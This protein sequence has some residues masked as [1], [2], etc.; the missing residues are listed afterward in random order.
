MT[1]VKF[2][3]LDINECKTQNHTCK[4]QHEKCV[5]LRPGYECDCYDGYQRKNGACVGEL[6]I[7]LL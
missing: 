3:S 1:S 5:N 4:G 2:S 7:I 6:S